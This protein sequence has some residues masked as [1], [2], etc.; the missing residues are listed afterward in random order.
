MAKFVRLIGFMILALAFYQLAGE[1]FVAEAADVECCVAGDEQS[2]V[3]QEDGENFTIPRW[4]CL[5]DAEL[6]GVSAQPHTLAHLR[7]QRTHAVEYIFSLKDCVYRLSQYKAVLT[8]H[9]SK[10]YDA[11]AYHPIN[12]VC[13]YFVFTL[14]RILI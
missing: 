6:A 1:Q 13:E 9:R 14:R 3:L 7:T 10:L 11:T 12:P 8:R 5:P 2:V 4:P